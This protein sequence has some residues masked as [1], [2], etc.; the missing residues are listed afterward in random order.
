[1]KLHMTLPRMGAVAAVVVSTIVG[2]APSASAADLPYDGQWPD[3]S[4]CASTG[5]TAASKSIYD[6]EGVKVGLIEL[7]YSTSCRTAWARIR[8]FITDYG[9]QGES[10]Y[11]HR[12]SDGKTF[13][14]TSNVYSSALGAYS[15]YTPMV[16]DGGVTSYAQGSSPGSGG[17]LLFTAF[18]SSY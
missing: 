16:Y 15:C 2:I 3:Q 11:V 1:M 9:G 13:G 17:G 6:M 5:I 18:T 10:A 4:G 7:R 12:N 14:C 8:S